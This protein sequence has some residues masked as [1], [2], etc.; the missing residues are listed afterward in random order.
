MESVVSSRQ[1]PVQSSGYVV[2]HPV[3]GV[4]AYQAPLPFL[5]AVGLSVGMVGRRVKVE[6][7]ESDALRC[8][9]GLLRRAGVGN[10]EK[11]HQG[12]PE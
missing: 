3:H 8:G 12:N 2:A 1:L 5:R 11:P 7:P 9:D 4:L 6:V 10:N